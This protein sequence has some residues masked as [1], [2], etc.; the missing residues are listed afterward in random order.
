MKGIYDALRVYLPLQPNN[1]NVLSANINAH[2]HDLM[3]KLFCTLCARFPGGGAGAPCP[4]YQPQTAAN[5]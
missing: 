5:P 1:G 2:P 4:G 3:T